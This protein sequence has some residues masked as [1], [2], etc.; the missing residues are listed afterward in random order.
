[1]TMIGAQLIISQ[2]LHAVLWDAGVYSVYKMWCLLSRTRLRH[3][4]LTEHGKV[5]AGAQL[6]HGYIAEV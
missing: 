6:M 3:M 4:V 5:F 1:M 2:L